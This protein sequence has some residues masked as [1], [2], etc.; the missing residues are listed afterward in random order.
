M[1]VNKKEED[2]SIVGT[3]YSRIDAEAKVT[4]RAEYSGDISLR[5]MLWGKM[6]RSPHAHAKIISIDTSKAAE[7]TGV[8]AI[9]T[10]DDFTAGCLGN[11]E[12]AKQYADK[13]PLAKEKVRLIGDEV[14]A[15]AAV[16]EAT[17]A[18][19]CSL[20][21]VEYEVLPPLFSPK[22][23]IKDGA[24]AIHAPGRNN[25]G[26]ATDLKAGSDIE[27]AFEEA[28]Y[29]DR[30][31]YSTHM[32]VHGAMEPHAAVASYENGEYK[33]WSSTQTASVCR[34][35]IA[36]ALGVDESKVRVIKPFVGGGFGGKLDQFPHE[37]CCCVLSEKAGRPV[38]MVLTREEVFYASRTRH[39]IDFVIETA[40]KKDG[41]FLGKKCQHLLDGGAYGGTGMPATGLS[42]QWATFPYKIPSMDYEAKRVYTNNPVSGAMRGYSSCQVHFANDVHMDEV[43]EA[44]DID[45]IEIRKKNG[46]T[47][48]YESPAGMEIT[49]C[50]FID[51]L[52]AA[53]EALN[54]K[55]QKNKLPK[56]EGIGFGG[57]GF[58]SGTGFPILNSP[59]YSSACVIVRLNRQGYATVFTGSND[60]GQGSDTVMTLIAA[61]EL[62]LKMD[63][64]KIV[65]SDTTLTPF[66]S[67]TYGSRVTFLTGN[68]TRRAA[69]DAK[70]QVV[71]VVARKFDVSPDQILCRDHNFYVDSDDEKMISYNDAVYAYQDENGGKEVVGIGAYAHKG[72]KKVY[73]EGKTNFAPTYSFSTGGAK[74]KVDEETGQ[75]DIED[76]VFAHDCGRPL[77]LRA[78]EGQIEGSV[79]MGLGYCLYEECQVVDGKMKNPSFRD[80]RFPTALD[81]PEIKTIL[82]G[83]P[84]PDGPFGAKECGEGSTA[85]VA[86]AIA[87]AVSKA[88]GLRLN[89]L[90]LTAENIWRLLKE[91]KE[92]EVK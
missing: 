70:R 64:V 60:I 58:V 20:I 72:D 35:W 26:M 51:T 66:D 63:E 65:V 79:H 83:G 31:E 85:P 50:A 4:G 19:A 18:K 33:L 17:A 11:A 44:L 74:V 46:M 69:E 89:K 88:T 3:N 54:W 41:T 34:F 23:A 16:D 30:Y 84:D 67:G 45:P 82:C 14:A 5:G 8:K 1:N 87:N 76:F 57:S 61:E 81:M 36:H 2:F 75:V 27:K 38:K 78:V 86:P 77:N 32:I 39:P 73:M 21:K 59:A 10:G 49:S 24:P 15:V 47:P 29:T 40:F 7:L 80:Y 28:D 91:K 90:P 62:G 43:A 42:L 68:A 52:D 25:V 9:I 55:E 6:V 56:W 48:G 12:F 13:Y 37:A 53:S 22:D 92:A 71:D